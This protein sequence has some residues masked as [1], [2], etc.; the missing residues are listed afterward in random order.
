MKAIVFIQWY[1]DKMPAYWPRFV[2]C[3]QQVDGAR[4][5]VLNNVEPDSHDGNVHHVFMPLREV[6][7]RLANLGVD[8]SRMVQSRDPRKPCDWRPLLAEL[9]PE[10]L[11]VDDYWGWCDTDIMLGSFRMLWDCAEKGAD[12]ISTAYLA[13]NGPLTLL[14][15]SEQCRTL[16]RLDADWKEIAGQ[17]QLRAFDEIGFGRVVDAERS[18]GMLKAS[19]TYCHSHSGMDERTPVMPGLRRLSDGRLL[20]TIQKREI[21]FFHFPHWDWWPEADTCR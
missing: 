16:Y 3:A 1:G 19:A 7:Q 10:Y 9:F 13:S 4:F 14:R 8:C 11:D 21:V 15:N 6:F 12:V 17:P 18:A 2:E 20:D 5:V